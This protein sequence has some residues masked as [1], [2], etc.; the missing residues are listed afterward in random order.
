MRLLSLAITAAL[1]LPL[2]SGFTWA[3]TA[4]SAP[5][6]IVNVGTKSLG[7]YRHDRPT[8][9]VMSGYVGARSRQTLNAKCMMGATGRCFEIIYST[10]DSAPMIPVVER[11]S[12]SFGASAGAAAIEA[13]S[14][15]E[16]RHS[17]FLDSLPEVL[18]EVA[19]HDL[20]REAE[21]NPDRDTALAPAIDGRAIDLRIIAQSYLPQEHS[22]TGT[23]FLHMGSYAADV[24]VIVDVSGVSPSGL[25]K[26]GAVRVQGTI[27][28]PV[29][30]A[31]LIDNCF[32]QV[33]A[34]SLEADGF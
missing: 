15:P 18:D 19:V 8:E 2:L 11:I 20:C 6:S 34:S 27:R 33:T 4:S 9:G 10:K 31:N 5:N 12:G 16:E 13:A 28:D 3:A 21:G 25:Q 22:L 17:A 29:F 23:N 1:W 24:V 7:T 30:Y 32:I 14:I 26:G